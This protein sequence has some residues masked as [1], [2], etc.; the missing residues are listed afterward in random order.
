M[1]DGA[2]HVVLRGVRPVNRE[3]VD[4]ALQR[5][6]AIGSPPEWAREGRSRLIERQLHALSIHVYAWPADPGPSPGS[7]I[8]SRSAPRS[9][10]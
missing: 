3:T 10:D 7:R 9:L 6:V 2:I 1:R 4:Q 8:G 5:R